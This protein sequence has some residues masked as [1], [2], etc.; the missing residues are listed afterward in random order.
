MSLDYLDLIGG[1]AGFAAIAIII[2][3]F[4]AALDLGR[5]SRLVLAG[6]AGAWTGLAVILSAAGMLK[7]SPTALVPLVGVLLAIPLLIAAALSALSSRVRSAL[8]DIPMPLLIGLNVIRALGFMFLALAAVGRLSGPF[9]YSA[10]I[11]DITTGVLAG[12]IALMAARTTRGDWL[13]AAWNLFGTMDLVA[14]I[15]LGIASADGS[16]LQLIHAG[17]GSDAIQSLPFSL[18]PTVLVPF[19]LITHGIVA[20]QLVRRSRES[21]A[22]AG[23]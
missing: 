23:A 7:V 18:I 6:A 20:A 3:A 19:F 1:V 2:V 8:V 9:P 16:P 22:L 5:T 11:G 4:V 10:G 21:R 13:V 17:V 14:A 15:T 12:P